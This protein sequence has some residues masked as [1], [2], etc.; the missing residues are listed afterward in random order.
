MRILLT[1]A[2]AAFQSVAKLNPAVWCLQSWWKRVNCNS[3]TA[4]IIFKISFSVIRNPV[5]HTIC[6][7]T[8]ET[9]RNIWAGINYTVKF[10]CQDYPLDCRKLSTRPFSEVSQII[11]IKDNGCILICIVYQWHVYKTILNQALRLKGSKIRGF[12]S[13]IFRVFNFTTTNA[14]ISKQTSFDS[15]P[16]VMK[17]K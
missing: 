3:L 16:A 10:M 14:V 9:P 12:N 2:T 1:C 5:S 11:S 6:N 7:N 8:S 4:L 13:R 17:G 15:V